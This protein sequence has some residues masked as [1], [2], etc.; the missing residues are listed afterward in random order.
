MYVFDAGLML[1]VMM[2]FNYW[3]PSEV[4]SLLKG[5]KMAKGW[6]IKDIDT[7]AERVRSSDLELNGGMVRV[8]GK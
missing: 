7:R 3:H 8:Q 2:I 1:V 4:G 5:G 6:R